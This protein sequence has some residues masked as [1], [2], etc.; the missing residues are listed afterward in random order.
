MVKRSTFS[1]KNLYSRLLRT[2]GKVGAI[3]WS[4]LVLAVADQMPYKTRE[5]KLKPLLYFKFLFRND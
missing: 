2:E 3:C 5:S 1:E 4:N